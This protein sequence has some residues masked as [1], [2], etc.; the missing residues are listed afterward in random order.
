MIG[1]R[2]LL[3]VI[4]Y[5]KA[6]ELANVYPPRSLDWSAEVFGLSQDRPGESLSEH[7]RAVLRTLGT[8]IAFDMII[9]NFD[10]LPCIW[11]NGGNAGNIMFE[12][13]TGDPL[14]I[15]NMVC[16]IPPENEMA[17]SKYLERVRQIVLDVARSPEREHSEFARIRNFLRE[18]C[19][20]G[21]GWIGLGIEVGFVGTLEVQNGF[22]NLVHFAVYGDGGEEGGGIT[23]EWLEG[24]RDALLRYLPG[25]DPLHDAPV[26]MYGFGTIHPKFCASVVDAF[27]S[28]LTQATEETESPPPAEALP[29]LSLGGNIG[30]THRDRAAAILMVD[31]VPMPMFLSPAARE[32]FLEYQASRRAQVGDET[33]EKLKRK[34][35][36]A[37]ED[38]AKQVIQATPEG[39]YPMSA[40]ACLPP[41]PKGVVAD[42][43]E[44]WLSPQEFHSIFGMDK[45]AFSAL[46]L[47]TRQFRKKK[48]NLF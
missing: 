6:V 32:T 3:L 19:V 15:D 34:A 8:L 38:V 37:R 20:D 33:T 14:S 40:L 42:R 48:V 46:P 12:M 28:A 13:A 7:G 47:W 31:N 22:L 17:S 24:I 44:I 30:H 16:C 43:R 35:A 18:G 21:H 1:R 4:E 25:D 10:R 5:V 26:H 2:P 27:R 39:Y 45:A 41:W 23:Q 11:E 9:N 36:T 29:L